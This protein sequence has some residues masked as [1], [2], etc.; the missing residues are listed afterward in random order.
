MKKIS[1]L[2][3]GL[4]T[5]SAASAASAA[6][7]FTTQLNTQEEFDLWTYIDHNEDGKTWIFS[8]DNTDG[9]RTYYNYSGS[10]DGDDW[11]I[12]PA[13][14]P[15]ADGIYIA[16]YKFKGSSYKE[17]M[18]VYLGTAPT[19]ENLSEGL[20]AE[21]PA[22]SDA[23]G[24]SD[25]FL[26]EGKAGEDVY[27]GFY[28]CTPADRFRLYLQ[29]VTVEACD[30][31]ADLAVTG[32]KAPATGEG[33][34]AQEKVTV[35]VTNRGLTTIDAFSITIS[36]DGT[37]AFTEN[38]T[39]SL[40]P[41]ESADILLNGTVDLSRVRYTYT[42]TATVVLD[43]DIS[44]GNNTFSTPVR[45]IGPAT[46]PYF[47]GFEPDEDTSDLKF[48]DLNNDSGNWGI[49][50]S[51]WMISMSRT[52][53]GCLG[54]NYD[55]ENDADDWAILDGINVEAGHHV[56]KFWLSGDDDHAERLSVHYGNAAE[57]AAMTN[58]LIRF[59]P[60]KHGPYQE[61]ICIFELDKPQTIYIG[62]HAFSDKDENW[63]T[64]DDVSLDKISATEADLIVEKINSSEWIPACASRDLSFTVRNVGIVDADAVAS[65]YVDGEKKTSSEITVKAQE[66][67]D[68]SLP[69]AL[70]GI[71]EGTHEIK[72][73]ITSDIDVHPE[74]NAMT[75]QARFL[76]TP[77]ILYDFEDDSQVDDLTFR[78]EDSNELYNDDF[79]EK[80]WG[81][82]SIEKHPIY[83]EQMLGGYVAFTDPTARADRWLVLPKI[84]VDSEDAC[85]VW[86]AGAYNT[87]GGTEAYRAEVSTGDDKW[88]DYDTALDVS[89]ESI[90]RATR[91][92]ELGQHNG[93]EIYV[94]LHIRS[95]N[96]NILTFDN[97]ELHGCSKV[98]AGV[99]S[100]NVDA[101]TLA[102]TVKDNTI[103]TSGDDTTQI[104]VFDTTGASVLSVQGNTADISTLLPGVYVARATA[105]N[106]SASIKL[107]RD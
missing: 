47:M 75:L 88:Y 31:P 17:A 8:P 82:L 1:L 58:E 86:N 65:V 64:I 74:N 43:G 39:R 49:E 63:I 57:P 21:Y 32:I 20:K 18:K 3:W 66:L 70:A 5:A 7:L 72:V 78:N 37:E 33:L 38:V 84:S 40:A 105:G 76:G 67:R 104:E 44:E 54:Y 92:I 79:G 98:G 35:T 48:F 26:F 93:K 34:T 22:I 36:V 27:I 4:L 13:I 101:T 62:F 85:F 55:K 61:V 10:N 30:N 9:Q 46:E 23:E 95:V 51:S 56:L 107:L 97:L 69:G 11:L 45:H 94:A 81:L 91:G 52:G 77:S 80:G 2:C 59:D 53:V 15:D 42:L 24:Q 28:A 96:G 99:N 41:G 60:F 71:A 19:I 87:Y 90:T 103:L 89:A 83:G 102:M 100:V 14:T 16:R 73:E 68:I 25:Y 6:P 106:A 12:S 50:I 29:G